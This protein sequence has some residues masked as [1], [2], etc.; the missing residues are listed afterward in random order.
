MDRQG[1]LWDFE[2]GLVVFEV[3]RHIVKLGHSTL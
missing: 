3:N 1:R 2:M